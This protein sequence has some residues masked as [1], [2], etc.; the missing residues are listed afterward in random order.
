MNDSWQPPSG[1]S[2]S[3]PM[4]VPD[5]VPGC[6]VCAGYLD[7]HRAARRAGDPSAA[8]DAR[9]LMRRHLEKQHP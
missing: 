6:A 3:L 9:V 4:R 8:A 1:F 7:Q 5:P 2:Y